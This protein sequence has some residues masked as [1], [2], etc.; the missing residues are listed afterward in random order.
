MTPADAVPEHVLPVITRILVMLE[1]AAGVWPVARPWA[2]AFA[3]RY[4]AHVKRQTS[5]S[6]LPR[7]A[8]PGTEPSATPASALAALATSNRAAVNG[9][10]TL[11]QEAQPPTSL[12]DRSRAPS[13]PTATLIASQPD[14]AHPRYSSIAAS[15]F[16]PKQSRE[17]AGPIDERI[18][19]R[20]S[21]QKSTFQPSP[22]AYGLPPSD[23]GVRLQGLGTASPISNGSSSPCTKGHAVARREDE[24]KG[25]R[26]AA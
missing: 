25:Q 24:E 11:P 21:D 4:D 1:D 16:R 9:E 8:A 6:P 23:G 12:L 19:A 26:L 3:L 2:S 7:Y 15:V 14:L 13:P 10:S 22:F 18:R 5:T 17:D 20:S